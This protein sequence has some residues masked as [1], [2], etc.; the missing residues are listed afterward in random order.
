M[1][2]TPPGSTRWGIDKTVLT[3]PP[4]R[5]KQLVTVRGPGAGIAPARSPGVYRPTRA[6]NTGAKWRKREINQEGQASQDDHFPGHLHLTG[7]LR[8][9]QSRAEEVAEAIP[10]FTSGTDTMV[11]NR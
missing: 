9:D 3:T 7:S 11:A 8:N 2:R 6:E 5:R 10:V 1:S 4:T